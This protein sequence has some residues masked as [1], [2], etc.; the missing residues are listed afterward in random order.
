MHSSSTQ[1]RA[2]ALVL[3]ALL[4]ASPLQAQAPAPASAATPLTLEWIF[5]PEGRGVERVPAFMWL[6]DGSAV[7]LDTRRPEAEQT[8][9]R[10]DPATGARQPAL[11]AAT[12]LANL[13]AL[14]PDTKLT[15]L[16]WPAA[17]DQSGAHAA[18][19]LSGDVFVLDLGSAA[20]SRLTSTP[21]EE[22]NVQ[23]SPD[24][25]RLAFVR[26]NDLY[27]ADVTSAAETR[28][29]N[30][31][32]PTV[33]NGSLSWVYWEEIFG[34]RETGYWWAPDGHAIAFL[35]TDES[36]VELS[37]FV[38]IAPA[39]PR[40]IEQR[41]PKAGT[42]NPRVRVGVVDL[43][44]H[45]T[46]WLQT[47][48]PVV[49]YVARVQWLPDSRRVAIQTLTRDQRELTLSFAAIDTGAANR[50]LTETD[51]GWVNVTDDLRFLEDGR[52]F[53]WTSERDG[54]LHLYRYTIDGRLVNQVTRGKWALASSGG[55]VYWVR[56]SIAGVD[57]R[58]GWIYFTALEKSSVERHLYRIR[59]DGTGMTRI[60]T[61]AGTHGITMSPDARYYADAFSDIRTPPALR[62]QRADGTRV[63]ELSPPCAPA[64]AGI[65]VQFPELTTVPAS[66]GFGMPAQFLKP[67]NFSVSRK[68]PVVLYVY[69]GPNA[70]TVTNGWQQYTLYNQLLAEAGYVVVQV[71][72]RAATGIS[73][74]LENTILQ[75]SGEPES[76]DLVD[77]VRWLKTQAWVDA[78]RVGVW[79]WSGGGTM[80]LNLMT[81]STEFK[82]G[83]AI[84]PVTDWR[85]YDTKW[86]EAFMKRPQD[87]PEGYER[88]SIVKR[89]A[90]LHGTLMLVFGSYDDNVHPQNSLAF[91]DALITAAK[92]FQSL[93]YPMRKHGIE[94]DPAQRNLFGAM[95]AFWRREL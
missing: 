61:E 10:I 44:A 62:L 34:R 93:V 65:D 90:S 58:D 53:L 31:G 79:G 59:P 2:G 20:F 35:Q 6:N 27:V 30:D 28:L 25:R 11:V 95:L 66:D 24:G 19:V 57:E 70:P 75:R 82:A 43:A 41:Y 9:E 76:A 86:A 32:S 23:F 37:H 54:Y 80:T 14:L 52:H 45:A 60:S 36:A 5:G 94:D 17:F 7:M 12:A 39:T 77:A 83:V 78:N 22:T 48:A 68:Y 46:T 67:K 38:D 26:A 73:K 15:A 72:N 55:A 81:R 69:G 42:S 92:P 1:A 85:Y 56:Q 21:A 33:L 49:E 51:P 91:I 50:I 40:V 87:N 29:T 47:A 18:Y 89:A 88:T 3:L 13:K 64:P 16:P 74:R 84:A 4:T 8:F 71:D 63:A